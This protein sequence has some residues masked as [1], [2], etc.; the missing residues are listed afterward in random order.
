MIF[1]RTTYLYAVEWR[2]FVGGPKNLGWEDKRS[3]WMDI[4]KASDLY[5]Q[6]RNAHPDKHMNMVQLIRRPVGRVAWL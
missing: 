5:R 2:E 1:K 3:D 6:I 4:D